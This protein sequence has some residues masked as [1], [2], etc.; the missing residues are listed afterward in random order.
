MRT[1]GLLQYIT[2]YTFANPIRLRI[3]FASALELMALLFFK[4]PVK[5][6]INWPN[7]IDKLSL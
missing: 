2:G 3:A 4:I 6:G 5:V 1:L 7:G